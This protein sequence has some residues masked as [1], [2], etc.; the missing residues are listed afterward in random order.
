MPRANRYHI[1]GL[2][3]HVT[4][5][6][7][8]REFLLK[9]HHDKKRWLYWLY[10]AKQ[11]YQIS[12]LNFTV[13]SNHIHLL[14]LCDK[15]TNFIPNTI[16]L[17]SGRIAW[18]YNKRKNRSGA[19]WEDRYHATAVE[20]DTYLIQC[21]IYIDLNMVRASVV[22]HPEDWSF[23]GYQE[24]M[25]YKKRYKLIDQK[26]LLQMLGFDEE[27]LKRQYHEL[28]ETH[29][30]L[31]KL[32]KDERWTES[33]AVG[34]RKFVEEIQSRLG[35]KAKKSIIYEINGSFELRKAEF[36]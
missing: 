4:Q 9:F 21:M 27:R 22:S 30:E 13:T 29:M 32:Q 5:R 7:H 14:V 18:E 6:C 3:W 11:R 17:A 24:I 15:N 36:P 10:K 35:D 16:Q 8:K 25:G 23:C 2:V 12:I 33:I 26:R 28:I 19:F 34:S 20:T 1:P 31:K